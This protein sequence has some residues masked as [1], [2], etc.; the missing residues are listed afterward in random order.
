MN[1]PTSAIRLASVTLFSGALLGLSSC[2]DA[3]DLGLELPGT[4]PVSS[5][6]RDFSVSAYTVRQQP[7]ETINA[8]H[9]LVGRVRDS[10]VGVTTAKSFLNMQIGT[11]TDS[12]PSKYTETKLDSVVLSL[13]YDQVYGTAAK[14]L[15]FDLL[16]LQQPLDERTVYN[17]QSQVAT[18]SP[19][20]SDIAG[21]LNRDKVVRQRI[22]PSTSDTSTIKVTV[23]DRVVRVRFLKYSQ[24]AALAN[25][26][27]AALG[28]ASFNQ[29]RLDAIIR[30]LALVPTANAQSEDNLVAF[31]RNIDTRLTFYFQGKATGKTVRP[32]AYSVFFGNNPTRL[33]ADAKF[34]TNISTELASPLASLSTPLQQVSSSTTNGETYVQE[35]T[36]LGTRIDFQGLDDL[37]KNGNEL[38]INRAEL[39][40]PIKQFT[41]G[42]FPYASSVY[43]QEVNSANQVLLRTVGAT[44]YERVVQLEVAKDA[45]GNSV[46]VTPIDYRYPAAASL[47]PSYAE[48][49]E[50]RVSMTAY[51]QAYL[52]DRL[53]GEKPSGLILSPTLRSS[54]ALSLNRTVLDANGI[55]LRIYFSTLK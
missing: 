41:N 23:P 29:A 22:S 49:S 48:P 2:E 27:Y 52:L 4:S 50:Y 12:L 15:R 28:D 30:G 10:K 32:H 46:L 31:N 19:L 43:L 38:N 54:T 14:P 6:F 24:T 51:L 17:S 34:F 8:S 21:F 16:Q 37:T 42:L 7:V 36:G 9:F 40:I 25:S 5:A 13:G 18:S 33:A 44:D 20:I 39:I 1:W 35:G 26:L 55:K 47:Y 45:N 3:T 11:S 53:N